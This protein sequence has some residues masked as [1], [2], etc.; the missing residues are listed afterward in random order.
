MPEGRRKEFAK[1]GDA[2]LELHF[3]SALESVIKPGCF[4]GPAFVPL[5]PVYVA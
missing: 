5:Q 3:S 2:K 4:W 1:S